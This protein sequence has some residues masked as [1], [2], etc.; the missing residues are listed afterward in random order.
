MNILLLIMAAA[1]AVILMELLLSTLDDAS[2]TRSRAAVTV[3][4]F[5]VVGFGL[6]LSSIL[7]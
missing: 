5:I 3:F 7:A 6:E 1:M 4:A 2:N